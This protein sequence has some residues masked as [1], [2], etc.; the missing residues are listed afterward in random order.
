MEAASTTNTSAH[1]AGGSLFSASFLGLLAT[2]FLTAMNDNVF[3]RLVI[4][5]GKE[6]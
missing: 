5:I 4:G 6:H 1:T 2:Q 3:R